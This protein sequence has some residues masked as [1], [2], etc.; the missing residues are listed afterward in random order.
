MRL[1]NIAATTTLSTTV[2]IYCCCSYVVHKNMAAAA[3][4]NVTAAATPKATGENNVL[5][6]QHSL[7]AYVS[8][9]SYIA[10]CSE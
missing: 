9:T 2:V 7:I 6:M 5:P 8:S 4:A 3:S 1:I 10:L